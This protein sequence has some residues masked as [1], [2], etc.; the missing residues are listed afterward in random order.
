[1]VKKELVAMERPE[2]TANPDSFNPYALQMGDLIQIKLT[3]SNLTPNQPVTISDDWLKVT[4]SNPLTVCMPFWKKGDPDSDA[5][6]FRYWNTLA[7]TSVLQKGAI[8]SYDPIEFNVT[9]SESGEIELKYS[10]KVKIK[11]NV[12]W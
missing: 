7:Y 12:S 6:N 9:P 3:I 1:V 10:C 11:D 5:V 2:G 8:Q 4:N